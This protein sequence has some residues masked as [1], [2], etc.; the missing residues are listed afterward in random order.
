MRRLGAVAAATFCCGALGAPSA[1]AQVPPPAPGITAA[2][3]IL[4]VV[5]GSDGGRVL[6]ERATRERRP[7][8]SLTKVVTALVAR[9]EYD[10]EEVVTVGNEVLTADGSNLGLRP[11]MRVPVRDLLYALLLKSGNDAAASL[12]AHHAL[13]YDHFI[14]LM[15]AK[16][17]A[18][19]AYGSNFANPHGLDAPGHLS[20]AQDMAIFARQL[21]TDPVLAEMVRTQRYAMPWPEGG[22]R[23]LTNH[24][25]LVAQR[26]GTIGVKTGYTVLAGHCLIAAVAT[27]AGTILSVVLSSQGPGGYADSA[28]LLGYGEAVENA[29]RSGGGPGAGEPLALPPSAPEI[30]GAPTDAAP[31][32]FD[33]RDDPR[34]AW[35][36]GALAAATLALLLARHGAEEEERAAALYPWLRALAASGPRRRG[37]R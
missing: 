2:S 24:N 4:V 28:A 37:R 25:K 12:A 19:G 10:L 11:G 21:L 22:T 18:L 29:S 35:L 27:P 6:F 33:P 32:P 36:G 8:A 1:T 16:A 3:A 26:P 34:W 17:R 30:D 14:R 9:D 31:V 5:S 7:P 23:F 13:G 15:N 20:T